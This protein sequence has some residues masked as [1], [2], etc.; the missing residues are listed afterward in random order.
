MKFIKKLIPITISLIVVGYSG[1][2][3][4]DPLINNIHIHNNTT[5][6]VRHEPKVENNH[7]VPIFKIIEEMNL[8]EIDYD[9]TSI[10]K[11]NNKLFD[12]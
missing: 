3:I 7:K 11:K 12:V 1:V 10:K 5:S 2:I 8:V 9:K 4:T 6:Q